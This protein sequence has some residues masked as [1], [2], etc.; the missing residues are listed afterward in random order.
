[1]QFVDASNDFVE[2]LFVQAGLET[3]DAAEE[4]WRRST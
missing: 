4:L 1:M 3:R 2:A